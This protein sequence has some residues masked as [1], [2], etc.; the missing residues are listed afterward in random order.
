M[1]PRKTPNTKL[2]ATPT[3]PMDIETRAPKMMR[4]NMSCPWSLAPGG[5][6]APFSTGPI[7]W[8]S[9]SNRPHSLYVFPW[10]KSLTGTFL[11]SSTWNVRTS[12]SSFSFEL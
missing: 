8:R 1:P 10:A 12:V 9:D 11:D 5:T 3:R 2:R 6:S 4:L 7:R